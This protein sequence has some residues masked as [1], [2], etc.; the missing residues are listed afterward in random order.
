MRFDDRVDHTRDLAN[1]LIQLVKMAQP[2]ASHRRV[3]LIEMV[4]QRLADLGIFGRSRP[5]VN[6]A[7]TTGSR[8]PSIIASVIRRN[9]T[10]DV[11]EV[12]LDS[13]IPAACMFFSNRWITRLRSVDQRLAIRVRFRNRRISGGGT[14]L[15]RNNPCSINCAIHVASATSVLRPGTLRMRAAFTS[16]YSN[17]LSKAKNTGRQ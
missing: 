13:L 5:L 11:A 7:S 14:K 9:V 2:A 6:S 10:D 4:D 17:W 8:C 3:V 12:T 1:G 15:G 16:I